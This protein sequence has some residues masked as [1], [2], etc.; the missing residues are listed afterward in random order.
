MS[1]RLPFIVLILA[2]AVFFLSLRIGARFVYPFPHLNEL[3]FDLSRFFAGAT[4]YERPLGSEAGYRDFAGLLFGLR[5]LTADVAWI[6][7]LQYYGAHESDA[8]ERE[9]HD[10]GGGEYPALDTLVH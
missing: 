7:V 8:E 2:L 4:S 10:F 1:R 9:R 6:G 5:R 3:T